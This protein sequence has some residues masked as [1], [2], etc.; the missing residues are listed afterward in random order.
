MVEVSLCTLSFWGVLGFVLYKFVPKI[1]SKINLERMLAKWNDTPKDV[2]IFH[3]FARGKKGPSGSPFVIKLEMF[4][5]M[6]K[7]PYKFDGTDP[8]GPKGKT[9]WISIN[10]KHIGDSQLA[11]EYLKKNST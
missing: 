9:P 11:L 5:R 8:F 4:L 1:I 3:G 10:G 6:A 7:I 2:V